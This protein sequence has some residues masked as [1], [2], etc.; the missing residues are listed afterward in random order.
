MSKYQTHHGPSSKSRTKVKPILRKLTQSEK[1]SLDL[2]ESIP[3]CIVPPAGVGH[4][5]RIL[6]L[7]RMVNAKQQRDYAVWICLADC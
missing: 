1:N 6:K 4:S 3:A 5:G 7:V 2:G